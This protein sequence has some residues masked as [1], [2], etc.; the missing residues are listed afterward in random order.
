MLL[1]YKGLV[2][3][4]LDYASVC[5]SRM[6]RTHFLKLERLQY[7]GLKIALGLMQS[8]PNN[9]LGVLSG[10]FLLAERC[11]YLNYRYLVTVF[12]KHGHPFRD[13]L[14]TLNRLN[15]ERCM[16]GFALVAQFTF[17]P[18]IIYEQ[19]ALAAL[20]SVPDYDGCAC[21]G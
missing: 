20:V 17:Q 5:Y 4:I 9:S 12:N 19:Y 3:S 7:Q 15:S 13:Q 6:A 8:T 10:V 21:I 14:E 18:S 2:G 1:L 11:M 16:K